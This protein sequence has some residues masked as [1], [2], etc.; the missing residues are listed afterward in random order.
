MKKSLK[1]LGRKPLFLLFYLFLSSLSME[2]LIAGNPLEPPQAMVTGKVTDIG[3]LPLTGVNVRVESK[4]IGAI[5]GLDGTYS[6][7]A[8]GS[9]V[10]I[11]SIVGFKSLPMPINGR[12]VIDVTMEE[13]VT[14]LGEVVLNAGYYTVSGRE[15]TGSI[16][17]VT[18]V[19]IE[20]QSISNP[21]AALQGRM[22]GVEIQ[23]TSGLPGA[24]FS[25]QI[26]GR[27]SI[28]T[29][30][31]EPLYIVD[32]MPYASESL[33]EQQASLSLP[34]R[35]ISP[36]NNINP[37]D[38]ESIEVLKDADATAIYGS[39]GANG[40]VLITT[41]TGKV[42]KTKVELKVNT[43][44]G[45]VFRTMDLLDTREYLA[46]RREAYANDGIS[47][48][49]SN[50]FDVNGTWD[51]DRYTDW[52]RKFFGRTSF[53][54]NFQASVSGG[55]QYTTFLISGNYYTQTSV[56]PKDYRN[57]K[58]SGLANIRHRTV[59]GRLSL[60][61]STQFV[62]NVNNLPGDASLVR[63]AFSLAPNAPDLYNGD[64]SLNWE[65]STWV[66][67]VAVLE[68]DYRSNASTLISNL[69]VDYQLFGPLAFKANLG[70]TEN[71]LKEINTTPSTIYDPIYG[72]G[73]QYSSA[74]HNTG[75]RTSWIVEPQLHLDLSLGSTQLDALAGASFQESRS[76]RL[77]IRASNF[78]SNDLIENLT[79]ASSFFPYADVQDQYRYQ[80]VFGRVNLNHLGRYILNLTG[81][82]DGSSRFGPNRRFANF[83]AVGLAWLFSE[84]GFIANAL[85]FLSH[86]KLRASHGSSGND[87]IGNYQYLDTYSF[88]SAQY[89]NVIGIYPTRL[90][91]PDFSWETNKKSEV[92]LELGFWNDRLSL[93]GSYYRNRSS[94]QLVGIPL[95][96]TT[97]FGSVNA[98]LGATV[99]NTGW[100]LGLTM[101]NIQNGDFLWTT[102]LNL[103]IPKN[104][105]VAFPDLE[106]STYANQLVVG[107]PLNINKVYRLNG[108]DPE[109]GLFTFEDFNG[110]GMISAL[111][112]R[113]VVKRLDPK[114]YGGLDNHIG[115][116]RF[117]FDV[118][119]QFTKQMGWNFWS[120]APIVGGGTNQPI[121]VLARWQ[122]P[123]NV[124][125]YQRFSSGSDSM[126]NQVF[127]TFAQSD[128]TI[129][130][131]SYI[132]LQNVS[133]SYRLA[134][135]QRDGF[136]CELFLRGQNL[137][138]ITDYLGLD[139]E[140]RN[141]QT[142]PTLRILS[143]GTRLTF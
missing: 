110:D 118:L 1:L 124:A 12:D 43:G 17:K 69:K 77:S 30:G 109:S 91:N 131:A 42:G 92:S 18:T 139:P 74:V 46:M 141:K 135:G 63:Q 78:S 40:V 10:L 53:L 70:Y 71:H 19:D 105:L 33:G 133:V 140:T 111:E 107:S 13:S 32:G 121:E 57:E 87:Q 24:N 75:K 29:G 117:S 127:R 31:S 95:P 94:N 123:G 108:V 114:F 55:D 62:A 88:G 68:R 101:V 58:V 125:P 44:L 100:E 80:A 86:G 14:A 64:G 72:V 138:T 113:E 3:G 81:R 28:R 93:S 89:Q 67:P 56:L 8:D 54:T 79:A 65:N 98:N 37:N 112:D 50:A 41:K 83:G 106:E 2:H 21:L 38:I 39:R 25:I 137:W 49:P 85:P 34:G 120:S 90:F 142:V 134:D 48:Y 61:L 27:N 84:E 119:F 76:N 51:S 52:Q 20:K 128:A 103:T 5:T 15:R 6:I 130:D 126:A 4:N 9:D 59:G 60:Q 122:E 132:R 16:E 73:P 143:L 129:S 26:R 22:V 136:G 47:D 97:G 116:D 115:T 82:R 7:D 104:R 36:L 99:E 23:Q 102:G 66:N 35:G 45:K 11:F 96:G